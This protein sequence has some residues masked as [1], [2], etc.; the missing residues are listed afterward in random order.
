MEVTA[1]PRAVAF[2]RALGFIKYD[3]TETSFGSAPRMQ[4]ML[5]RDTIE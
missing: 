5:E 4:R 2:Y 1:N 3:V